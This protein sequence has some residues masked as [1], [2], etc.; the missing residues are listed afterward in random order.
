VDAPN[1]TAPREAERARGGTSS[2]YIKA[3]PSEDRLCADLQKR[4]MGYSRRLRLGRPCP[5][6]HPGNSMDKATEGEIEASSQ[7]GNPKE[8]QGGRKPAIKEEP[9]DDD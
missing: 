1:S 9:V 2:A 7:T 4:I 3:E 6:A 8:E 5:D